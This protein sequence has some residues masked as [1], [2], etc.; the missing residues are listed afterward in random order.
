MNK[1][2]LDPGQRWILLGSKSQ[3]LILEI[4]SPLQ[5]KVK[6]NTFSPIDYPVGAISCWSSLFMCDDGWQLLL[7]QRKPN[8]NR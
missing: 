4:I 2:N 6:Y 8:E 5:H 3:I 7:T 1:F